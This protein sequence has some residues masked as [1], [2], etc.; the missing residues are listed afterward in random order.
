MFY[1]AYIFSFM[2]TIEQIIRNQERYKNEILGFFAEQILEA[3]SE[4]KGI[5]SKD[6][7]IMAQKKKLSERFRTTKFVDSV[8]KLFFMNKKRSSE[9]YVW[10]DAFNE[11]AIIL[12]Y[13]QK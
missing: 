2:H 10:W 13:E 6:E 11:E 1:K 9:Y 12:P 8:N 4:L 3:R 5:E 7:Y